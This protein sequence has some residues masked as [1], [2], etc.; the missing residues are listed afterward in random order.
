MRTGSTGV[1]EVMPIVTA[2]DQAFLPGLRALL[3]S[4]QQ[5]NPDRIVYLL[6]CGISTDDRIDLGRQFQTLRIEKIAAPIGLP[7]PSVG[8]HATY[9]RLLVGDLLSQHARILY[10]DADTIVVSDL[11]PLDYVTLQTHHIAA[12]CQEPYTPSFSSANGVADY[13]RLGFLGHEAYFNGGVLIIDT[14]RWNSESIK[15]KALSYLRRTDI[16]ITLF[17]QE[18][19]NVALAGRWQQLDP[20]WNVSRYWTQES[21]RAARPNILREARIVHF[22]SEDKPWSSPETTHPWLLERYEEFAVR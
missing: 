17:D 22:L 5:R 19:L 1:A 4:L 13:W 2:C 21:R 14:N 8:S 9:A 16:K 10:L 11:S 3:R 18:A 6:D 15:N 20:E 12:A 7:A